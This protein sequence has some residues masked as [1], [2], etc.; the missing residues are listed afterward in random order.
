MNFTREDVLRELE[1]LPVWKLRATLQTVAPEAMPAPEQVSLK[2]ETKAIETPVVETETEAATPA[3][4]ESMPYICTISDDKKWAFIWPASLILSASQSTL[5]SNILVALK[6][7]KSNQTEIESLASIEASIIIAMGE[8]AAQR[9]LNTTEPIET[10][11][12]KAH[13]LANAPL[14]VTYHPSDML[15]HLHL[16]AKTWEDLCLAKRIVLGV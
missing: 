10:L 4:A 12:G 16:K 9:V 5:F 11:R 3:T 6:I 7:S 1:L 13:Q 14:V 8:A 15:Q 2:I